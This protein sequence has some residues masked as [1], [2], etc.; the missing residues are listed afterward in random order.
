MNNDNRQ[1]MIGTVSAI[2]SDMG[3]ARVMFSDRDNM[4]S[5]ELPIIFTRAYGVE[6]Y[7][8]PEVGEEVLCVFLA[9][10]LEEGFVVGA[11]Y[12]DEKKPPVKDKSIKIIKFEDGNYVKYQNGTFEFKGNIV[13]DG[14]IT[15]PV[16]N[17]NVNGLCKGAH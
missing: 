11:Y 9:N 13:V 10:G 3:R 15:A 17:G 4:I 8:M 12:N 1:I 5:K 14:N 6:I 2:N 16:F 7:A